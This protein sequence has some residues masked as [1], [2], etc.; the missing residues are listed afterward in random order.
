M[1]IPRSHSSL[2]MCVALVAA[3]W[4]AV[5]IGIGEPVPGA[6]LAFLS[7]VAT[8]LCAVTWEWARG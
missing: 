6:F 3:I 2:F 7:G 4:C 1:R 5:S 8:A